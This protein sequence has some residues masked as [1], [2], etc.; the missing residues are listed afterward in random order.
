[1]AQAL[2]RVQGRLRKRGLQLVLW[3]CYRPFGIQEEFWKLA[4]DPRY[5]ARP[6]RREGK[7]FQGSKHNRGAAVDV[8]LATLDGKIL[9]M[10]TDHDDFSAKAHRH[11]EGIAEEAAKN[12]DALE[13][14]MVAEGFEGIESEWWHFDFAGW[15]DYELSEQSL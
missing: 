12:A 10:P 11:A 2:A 4:P 3:D 8:S 6:V 5:I 15:Q 13:S 1:M 14:A 7:P 9:P